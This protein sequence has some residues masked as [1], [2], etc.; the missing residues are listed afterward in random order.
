MSATSRGWLVA[1]LLVAALL[2]GWGAYEIERP[3]DD[4]ALQIGNAI[5]L[6]AWGTTSYSHWAHPPLNGLLLYGSVSLLGD[7]PRGWRTNNI[8][9]GTAS[10]LLLYL[11]GA[12]LFPG[13]AVPL[14]GAAL[15]ALDPFHIYNSRTTFTEVPVTFFFLLFLHF[16][17]E[18]AEK[19][20]PR[21]GGAGLAAGLTIATKGYFA[22]AIP[23]VV[24]YGFYRAVRRGER[25][26]TVAAD[27]ASALL[28]L[29][30]A[31]YLLSYVLWFGR[32]YSLLEFAQMQIDAVRSM[33][34]FRMEE[35][36]HRAWLDAGGTPLDWFTRPILFGRSFGAEPGSIRYLLEIN[37]FPF[38]VLSLPAL[39]LTAAHAWRRRSV[40]EAL[41]AALFLA[42]YALFLGVDRPMFSYS[43]TVALPFAYLAVARVV[44]LLSERVS[45]PS[46]VR[47]A[48]LALVLIWGLYVFPLAT[49]RT[50]P[51]AL[52]EPILP[53]VR[54]LG[55][56]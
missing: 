49:A 5:S 44:E 34:S 33:Q 39:A 41:P 32:G 23:L 18:F 28:L 36:M 52:Y 30:V 15:L 56:A 3:M 12:S 38:R 40:P 55:G 20:R 29:P 27:F 31:V 13:T 4:E 26:A 6:G 45:N 7:N 54:I 24:A 17:L 10:V 51:R 25:A 43:A 16:M 19:G 53:L 46:V 35:F 22:V 11:V 21:L 48:F 2:R 1:L 42:C 37:N 9:F 50:V 47:G 14:L 8:L